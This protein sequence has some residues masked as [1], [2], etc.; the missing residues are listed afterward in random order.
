MSVA[1]ADVVIL[2]FPQTP[3]HPPKRRLAIAVQS[4]HNNVR[5]T[6]SIFA[7]VTTN[8]R[9]VATEPAQVRLLRRRA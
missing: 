8:V 4:D 7:M 1:R 3:G 9:L 5:L 6:N 2:D